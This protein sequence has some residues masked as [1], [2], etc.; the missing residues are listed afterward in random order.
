MDEYFDRLHVPM[1]LI[2]IET[3]FEAALFAKCHFVAEFVD[4]KKDCLIGNLV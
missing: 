1:L 3:P 2:G 4:S